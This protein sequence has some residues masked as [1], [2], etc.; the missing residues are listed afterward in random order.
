MD[1]GSTADS[2]GYYLVEISWMWK[3]SIIP[4]GENK[5]QSLSVIIYFYE[6]FSKINNHITFSTER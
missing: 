4:F 5:D 2:I 6:F 1:I 3:F